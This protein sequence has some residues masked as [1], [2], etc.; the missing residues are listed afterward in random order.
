M[1]TAHADV[2]GSLLRPPELI[3]GQIRLAAGEID[4]SRFKEVEDCAVRDAIVMQE[5]AGLEIVT[6]GEMRRQSFQS[7]MTVAVEGFGDFGMD[8]FLWGEWHNAQGTVRKARPH[9]LGATG[10]L[11][12]KR[13]LSADEFTYLK[14]QTSRVA[15]ITLP[16]PSL[17]VN[18]WSREYSR[19]AYPTLDS[20]L[21]DIVQLLREE[22]QELVRL[23]A[24]YIHIDAPHYG[25]M[26][27][28]KTRRF[29]EDQGWS[30]GQW[31]T[32]GIEL[33]NAII[34]GFPDVTFALHL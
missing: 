5:A 1:I 16:S 33:D 9:N 30:L 23:G 7:Q 4:A 11:V 21:A 34:A 18:F 22:V 6:D 28:A 27:D 12:R 10:K 15:K 31:L 26:L 8:A 19:A 29:Y 2:V 25:L 32:R 24:R 13:Y 17:W 14:N 20:F 3:E